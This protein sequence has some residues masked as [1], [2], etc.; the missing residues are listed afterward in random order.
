MYTHIY[1]FIDRVDVVF[2]II[3]VRFHTN[4][5]TR[6]PGYTHY[7]YGHND[8]FVSGSLLCSLIELDGEEE[9][10]FGGC[11]LMTVRTRN[12][13]Y[14]TITWTGSELK[15]NYEYNSQFTMA[16]HISFGRTPRHSPLRNVRVNWFNSCSSNYI[17]FLINGPVIM[18]LITTKNQLTAV[19]FRLF[20]IYLIYG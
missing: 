16:P 11:E 1:F 13:W 12:R 10:S 17:M 7:G 15:N 18:E 14:D 2:V 8:T 6:R 20:A 9:D 4:P 19:N 3:R 5:T